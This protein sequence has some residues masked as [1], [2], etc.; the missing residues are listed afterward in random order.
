MKLLQLPNGT[1]VRYKRKIYFISE[2]LE[3]RIV[4][5]V[6]GHWQFLRNLN[7]KSFKVEFTP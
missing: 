7:W 6:N 5:D 1:V 4:T 2:G 3:A